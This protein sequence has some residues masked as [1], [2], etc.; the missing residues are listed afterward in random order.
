MSLLV[1][2]CQAKAPYVDKDGYTVISGFATY[3]YTNQAYSHIQPSQ[4]NYWNVA[5][6]TPYYGKYPISVSYGLCSLC[7][8]S[9]SS[10]NIL[11]PSNYI[12]NVYTGLGNI[13]AALNRAVGVFMF[14][15]DNVVMASDFS[16]QSSISA[17]GT[18]NLI[19]KPRTISG[20]HFLTNDYPYFKKIY[21]A[22]KIV[23]PISYSTYSDEYGDYSEYH[24]QQLPYISASGGSYYYK[25]EF[26][27]S[28][29]GGTYTATQGVPYAT[30]SRLSQ[31]GSW[32]SCSIYVVDEY[33][34]CSLNKVKFSNATLQSNLTCGSAE[35]VSLW[36][37][38]EQLLYEVI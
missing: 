35:V 12:Y 19:T 22:N 20:T 21:G 25:C 34:G 17:M 3:T 8:A 32:N 6:A 27:C 33:A 4:Y 15:T 18:R 24:Y 14:D 23:I 28:S 1:V 11:G 10:A 2:P 13:P 26:S 9:I 37:S 7:S 30:G 31:V 36:N 16:K 5:V 38:Y 29:C